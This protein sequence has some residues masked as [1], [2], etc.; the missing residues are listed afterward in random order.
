MSTDHFLETNKTDA[1]SPLLP[2]ETLKAILRAWIISY[3]THAI[4]RHTI[5][6]HELTE[7][8]WDL[9][10]QYLETPTEDL[11]KKRP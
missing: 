2:W 9:D 7:S 1:V 11:F 10:W 8:I 5:K 4:K 6:I 3:S